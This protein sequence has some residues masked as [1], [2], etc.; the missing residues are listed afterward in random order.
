MFKQNIIGRNMIS[1]K[2]EYVA[3]QNMHY[4]NSLKNTRV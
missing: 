1:I 2:I 4:I 3:N